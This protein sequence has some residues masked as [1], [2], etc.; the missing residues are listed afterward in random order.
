MPAPSS[1]CR[2]RRLGLFLVLYALFAPLL[3]QVDSAFVET[4][5]T[6]TRINGGLRYRDNGARFS[7]ADQEQLELKNRGLALRIGGRYKWLGYTFSIPISDLGTGSDTD[8]G[9]SLGANLQLFRRKVYLNANVRRTKGF[10]DVPRDGPETFREDVR[11]VNVL[12]FGFR[13]LNSNRFSIR[14]SFRMRERQLRSAGS[15]LV[16]GAIQRQVL[17][18]D[19]LKVPLRASGPTP[20]NRFNQSK[21]GVGLGYAHTF[22]FGKLW[23]VTPLLI[24]GPELRFV[25][26]DLVQGEREIERMQ[27]SARVRGRL[28]VGANG[29][30]RFAALVASYLPNS[31]TNDSFDTR[32]DETLVELVLGYRIGIGN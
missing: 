3:G 23:F 32:V 30:R 25:A 17:T 22:V 18:A 7:V 15:F 31:D 29:R 28:A 2:W 8:E 20:I 6:Q 21:V 1:G 16:G 27:L 11:F 10:I 9:S 5:T 13:I 12:L 24:A 26:Y 4:F 14:S 19:S